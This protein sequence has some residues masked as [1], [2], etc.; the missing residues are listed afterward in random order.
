MILYSQR[1]KHH[2]P[3]LIKGLLRFG[4]Q[5]CIRLGG[6]WPPLHKPPQIQPGSTH[7]NGEL[8]SLWGNRHDIRHSNRV[9]LFCDAN[10]LEICH[11][12]P[13]GDSGDLR[14]SCSRAADLQNISNSSVGQI[15]EVPGRKFCICRQNIYQVMRYATAVRQRNLQGSSRQSAGAQSCQRGWPSRLALSDPISSPLY[16]CIES[17]LMIS[18]S[19][20]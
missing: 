20:C 7:N 1:G 5:I 13:G 3:D 17:A 14:S 18:P 4:C 11:Y 6:L 16:T 9:E 2:V 8:A 19:S 10:V 15:A 12:D